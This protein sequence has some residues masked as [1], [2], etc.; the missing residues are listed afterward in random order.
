MTRKSA[1]AA[2]G[3]DIDAGNKAVELMRKAVR[4]TYGPEVLLG[5]G[6]F[7]GLYDGK[8]LKGMSGPVLVGSTDS[9]GT[10]TVIAMAMGSYETLGLDIVNHCVNDILV[11]GA[12][13]LFFLDYVAAPALDPQ[14]IAT[15]VGGV[16][17][18][19]REA[20]C[21]LLGGE[22]AELPGVYAPG[23]LDLVGAIVGLV[24][25]D[26]IIDGSS[27]IPGDVLIGLPSSGLH[28]NGFSLVRS[29]F[30]RESYDK[31]EDV[32]GRP[33]GEALVEA[34]RSYLPHVRAIRR[35]ATI[36]GLAHITGGGF[37]DNIPRILP[38]NIGAV[39]HRGAWPVPPLFQLIENEGKVDRDEMYRVFNMGT[40]M[41][42]I[43]ALT[44]VDAVL[45]AVDGDA[46]VM[47]VVVRRRVG[48]RVDLQ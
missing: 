41:V 35:V 22:T 2:A 28:T 9:V 10:K 31:Y 6:A 34:H 13:P 33:L 38:A 1:Y 27:I 19:C 8:R 32:L 20:G 7:G 40:G 3:V 24:E 11:Q 30:G 43:V 25:R 4:S 29:I 46:Y 5:I 12:E 15:I 45:D 42:V 37:V 18:A 47:G 21:A 14:V 48:E 26:E 17:A 23:Q 36:K 39:V 16:A 44:E